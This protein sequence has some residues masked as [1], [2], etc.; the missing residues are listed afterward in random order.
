MN[1]LQSNPGDDPV[2]VEGFFA[3]SPSTMFRAWTEPEIICKW[4]GLKPNSLV[5]ARVDLRVGGIWTFVLDNQAAHSASMQ[6]E[7]IE[8]VPDKK[9]AF[10]W[11]HV[12]VDESGHQEET[13]VSRVDVQFSPKG[14]GTW[15]HLEHSGIVREGAREGVGGGWV[16]SFGHIM[17]LLPQMHE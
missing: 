2:V 14:S 5:S 6:G 7:Y 4:F 9:L 15:V 8:I 12:V 13:P 10:T 3:V 11:K 16:N 17:E 1:L